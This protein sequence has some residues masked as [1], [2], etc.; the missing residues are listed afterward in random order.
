ML[1]VQNLHKSYGT[2]TVLAGANFIVNDKEHIGLIGPN[3][4]GKTTLFNSIVGQHPIDSGSIRFEGRDISRLRVYGYQKIT[5]ALAAV[6]LGPS[7][8]AKEKPTCGYVLRLR[9]CYTR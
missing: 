7:P 4:S 3:G 5:E 9:L 8:I 1:Q 6:E 2:T